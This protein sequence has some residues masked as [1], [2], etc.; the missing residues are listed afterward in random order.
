[1]PNHSFKKISLK[2]SYKYPPKKC[3]K[4]GIILVVKRVW[5]ID[6]K[7]MKFNDNELERPKTKGRG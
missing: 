3:S 1:M 7:V 2:I 4:H 6:D 5:D